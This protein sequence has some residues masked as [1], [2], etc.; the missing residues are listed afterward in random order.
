[1]VIASASI[2]SLVSFGPLRASADLDMESNP[3][4][5]V[6]SSLYSLESMQ[7]ILDLFDS[8][9][10]GLRALWLDKPRLV[11]T[12][13]FVGKSINVLGK[14]MEHFCPAFGALKLNSGYVAKL[15]YCS[16]FACHCV[17]PSV[18][19]FLRVCERPL[20]SQDGIDA[21]A[22]PRPSFPSRVSFSWAW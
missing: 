6:I 19:H 11:T 20:R 15:Y 10:V 2:S 16:G 1:M 5:N 18:S 13:A 12:R 9:Q 3:S 7:P 4:Q 8:W 21:L 17:C 22:L 14:W